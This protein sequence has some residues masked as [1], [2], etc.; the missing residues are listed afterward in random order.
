MLSTS[1]TA[2]ASQTLVEMIQTMPSSG[3]LPAVSQD[4]RERYLACSQEIGEITKNFDPERFLPRDGLSLYSPLPNQGVPPNQPEAS[5]STSGCKC[6]NTSL[7]DFELN[8][9]LFC[10]PYNQPETRTVLL[11]AAFRMIGQRVALNDYRVGNAT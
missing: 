10:W 4:L 1:S 3:L 6:E 7:N 11:P 9:I 8:S 5:T 2:T